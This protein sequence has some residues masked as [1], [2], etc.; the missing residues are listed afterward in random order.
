M[1]RIK[2]ALAEAR[3]RR[4]ELTAQS[5][6]SRS[7]PGFEA[8]DQPFFEDVGPTRSTRNTP[9]WWIV[10]AATLLIAVVT[11]A[12]MYN[13]VPQR[14]SL[15][16]LENA[17]P[18]TDG[19][20]SDVQTSIA[21]T[22]KLNATVGALATRMDR[23]DAAIARLD[24]KTRALQ[25]QI[26]GIG[27]ASAETQSSALAESDKQV[28]ATAQLPGPESDVVASPQMPGT[29]RQVAGGPSTEASRL[30]QG[31]P[32]PAAGPEEEIASAKEPTAAAA[33]GP[34]VINLVSFYDEPSA[35]R[36]AAR[37]EAKGVHVEQDQVTVKGKEYWRVRVPGFNSAQEA[38]EHADSIKAKLGLKETWIGKS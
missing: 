6:L 28:K 22:E 13:R 8:D 7:E 37:A 24:D 33:T 26:D 1:E 9:Q 21:A 29:T 18:H 15:S 17:S 5:Y 20:A 12:Y 10:G 19:M 3:Q 32:V 30:Q 16:A 31:A 11:W 25:E 35:A 2:R 4:E 36:F 34:W 27:T 14:V 23:L 38:T